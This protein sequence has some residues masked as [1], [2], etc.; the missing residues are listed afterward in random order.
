[1][2]EIMTSTREE[3]ENRLRAELDRRG[4]YDSVSERLDGIIGA[5]DAGG[6]NYQAAGHVLLMCAEI[7]EPL[8][9]KEREDMR[10]QA[11]RPV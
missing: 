5:V 3:I 6:T 4:I 1:M 8:R 9:L 2:D 11:G 7:L 10:R